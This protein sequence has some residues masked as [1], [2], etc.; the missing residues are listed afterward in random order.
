MQSY[1]DIKQFI[2]KKDIKTCF[3][4]IFSFEQCRAVAMK[5]DGQDGSY[6]LRSSDISKDRGLLPTRD[7]SM[8]ESPDSI[9]ELLPLELYGGHSR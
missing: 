9:V 6:G 3:S 2:L 8:L 4:F 7:D 1:F 5:T